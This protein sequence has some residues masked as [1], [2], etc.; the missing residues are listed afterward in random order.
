[1]PLG[2]PWV[3]ASYDYLFRFG[4]R[5]V[6]NRVTLI[7]M[8]NEAYDHF[9]QVRGQPWDRGLHA[10]LLNRL[11]DDGCGL[12]VFDS[13]FLQPGDPTTD[14]ALAQ[15]MRR[16]RHIVLGAQ[17]AE[18]IYSTL[19]G[20]QPTLPYERFLD[21]AGTNWGVACLDPEPIVRRHW[22]FPSPGPHPSLPWTAARLAGASLS[23]I[24]QERWLRYYGRDGA[25]TRLSYRFALDRPTNY[26][27]DQIVF[28]GTAPKTLMPGSE[29]DKFNTP[30]TR[31]TK[32]STGGVEI[33]LTSFLNL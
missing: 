31:W 24:P 14:E 18:V 10:Q 32:E 3:N 30:Y 17:Q 28:I 13:F 16:Q 7:L 33:L 23:E 29:K 21:A 19:N 25:A 9:H 22:P 4:A 27:R 1:M 6:T 5:A 12:V 2:D 20:V 11:A 15:A 26:F 8:D